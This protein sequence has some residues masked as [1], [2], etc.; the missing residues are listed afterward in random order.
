M[1]D[2]LSFAGFA[3]NFAEMSGPIHNGSMEE[4]DCGSFFDH[5]DDLL[6]FPMNDEYIDAGLP[7]KIDS[8]PSIWSTESDTVFSNNESDLSAQLPVPVSPT[9][10]LEFLQITLTIAYYCVN[11]HSKT[12]CLH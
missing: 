7:A 11:L 5:I 9:D 4:F 12:Y 6:D 8:F 1:I 3:G 10:I 2:A